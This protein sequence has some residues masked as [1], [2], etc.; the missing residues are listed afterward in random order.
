VAVAVKETGATMPLSEFD[1]IA[2]FFSHS[3][4]R[5]ADT[6]LSVGDD[7]ALL[8]IP[9]GEALAV[10]MDTLVEGRHF[11]AETSPRNI[12]HKALAVN[13]S[14]LAAMGAQPAWAMLSLS[15]P[16][17]NEHW[18]SEFAEGLFG[19]AEAHGV[20]LVGG[21]TV[22]GPLVITLQLHGFVP[23][24][25]ALK[26]SGAQPGDH[27]FVTGTL[28]D[29]GAGLALT[30]NSLTCGSEEEAY[31]RGR[32]DS[33]TPRVAEGLALRGIA[34][35]AIDVSDG[36][37]ADLGHILVQSGVGAHIELERLPLS[38]QIERSVPSEEAQ[39]NAL[40]AGDDY[41]LCFTVP[42]ENLERLQAQPFSF[43]RIGTIEAQ[44]GLRILNGAGEC[45]TVAQVGFDHFRET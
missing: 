4:V 44:T 45:V 35:A 11:P 19:L 26:R 24:A 13:L 12:G 30:R 14:D 37:M 18:L 28:G 42:P 39:R 10:T 3:P 2:R 25:A 23:A 15:L 36:L 16:E 9:P 41:E 7:C 1:V 21:D 33:P 6:I 38:P 27:I 29:A 5:R 17:V 43:T 20:E 32:L 34:S 40:S 22:R 8:S 31:L